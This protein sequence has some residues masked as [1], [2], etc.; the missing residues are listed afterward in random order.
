VIDL[1]DVTAISERGQQLLQEM[2]T[3]GAKFQCLRGV[4]TMHVVKRLIKRIGC[5]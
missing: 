3:E 4:L 2:M 5:L 1:R